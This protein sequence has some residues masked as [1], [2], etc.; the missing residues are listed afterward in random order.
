MKGKLVILLLVTL[1]AMT[2]CSNANSKT[3]PEKNTEQQVS[4]SSKPK[5]VKLM[6]EKVNESNFYVVATADGDELTYAYYVYKDGEVVD[7]I[8]YKKDAHFAYTVKEPGTYK[9][10]VY[11]KD[12]NDNK[13]IKMTN[14]VV[15]NP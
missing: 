4:E 8:L 6:I 10:E 7:K 15:M 12:K 3:E 14:E 5:F 1:F 2:A 13:A 11:L 9:V